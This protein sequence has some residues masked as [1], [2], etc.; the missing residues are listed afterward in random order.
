MVND[1]LV[2]VL[3]DALA[4]AKAG[5]IKAFAGVVLS[6]DGETFTELWSES[7]MESAVPFISYVRVLQMRFERE[8]EI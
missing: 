6:A 8:V 7:A 4:Q 2:E 3:E 1:E 5:E